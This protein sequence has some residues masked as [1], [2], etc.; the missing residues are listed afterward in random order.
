MSKRK[1]TLWGNGEVK[2]AVQVKTGCSGY[3]RENSRDKNKLDLCA[4]RNYSER[5]KRLSKKTYWKKVCQDLGEDV[6]DRKKN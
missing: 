3:E 1:L 2:Y 4:V 5:I 6:R